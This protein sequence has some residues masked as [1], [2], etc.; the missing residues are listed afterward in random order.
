[1]V[2]V[3]TSMAKIALNFV[4]LAL[5]IPVDFAVDSSA[6]GAFVDDVVRY[7]KVN[8]FVVEVHTLHMLM[9]GDGM[10]LVHVVANWNIRT[11]KII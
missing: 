3:K 8:Q 1:M 4:K 7:L 5:L 11:Q 2:S 10:H 9:M 6:F